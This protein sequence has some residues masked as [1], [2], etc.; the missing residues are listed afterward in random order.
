MV[1]CLT[2]WNMNTFKN[3]VYFRKLAGTLEKLRHEN[4]FAFK[5]AT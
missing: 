2:A 3:T 1:T 4:E 5:Y